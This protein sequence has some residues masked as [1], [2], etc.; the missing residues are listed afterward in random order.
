MG[1]RCEP[2]VLRGCAEACYLD[3][4]SQ[5]SPLLCSYPHPHFYF[6]LL[7]VLLRSEVGTIYMGGRGGRSLLI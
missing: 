5:H 2:V 4:L 7:R 3:N 1:A 6:L